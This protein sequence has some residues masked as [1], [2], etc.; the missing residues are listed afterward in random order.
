MSF[1]INENVN[2]DENI[3]D[4][5]EEEV[6]PESAVSNVSFNRRH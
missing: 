2:I 1:D 4:E 3:P 6:D 5:E